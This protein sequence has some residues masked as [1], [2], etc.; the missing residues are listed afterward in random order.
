MLDDFWWC[1][2]TVFVSHKS[3]F[4][5]SQVAKSMSCGG[6]GLS[7]WN[8]SYEW[9]LPR[10]R[11]SVPSYN[12]AI[13]DQSTLGLKKL[14]C[15]MAQ[16]CQHHCPNSYRVPTPHFWTI[17]IPIWPNRKYPLV[18]QANMAMEIPPCTDDSSSIDHHLSKMFKCHIWLP[19][20]N[21]PKEWENHTKRFWHF[22][23]LIDLDWHHPIDYIYIYIYI[24][25]SLDHSDKQLAN[26]Q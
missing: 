13:S 21:P 18:C 15:S 8:Q 6:S 22:T 16:V 4:G 17:F 3:K 24:N 26:A 19:E 9:K 5:W 1:L 12:S 10:L 11:S 23:L 7:C 25:G 20:G 14:S 2:M